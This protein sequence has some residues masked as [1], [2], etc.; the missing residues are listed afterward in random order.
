M[1]NEIKEYQSSIT[2]SSFDM[3]PRQK[4]ICSSIDEAE[5]INKIMGNNPKE[6]LVLNAVKG[7]YKI[8]V[9]N[10]LSKQNK[11]YDIMVICANSKRYYS[12]SEP[13][14]NSMAELYRQLGNDLFAEETI[15]TIV[16]CESRNYQGKKFYKVVLTA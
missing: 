2:F 14:M 1:E 10:P 3:S 8:H 4:I 11:K 9:E 5:S 12:G 16:S 6:G 15:L 7:F 13:L